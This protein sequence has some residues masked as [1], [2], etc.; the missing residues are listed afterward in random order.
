MLAYDLYLRARES[1][2]QNNYANSIHLLEQAISRD[3]QFA[4]AYCLLAEVHLY[5]YRFSD[6]RTPGRL[7]QARQA[8]E[9]ALRLAPKLPQSH[10]AKA[11]FYDYG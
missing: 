8:V 9:T 2:F 5:M 1:F 10:L 6:D 4:L 11:Q 3:P 7:D